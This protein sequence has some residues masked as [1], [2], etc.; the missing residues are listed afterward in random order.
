MKK[1]LLFSVFFSL[2]LLGCVNH[3]KQNMDNADNS[4]PPGNPLPKDMQISELNS[5]EVNTTVLKPVP[6]EHGRKI[7]EDIYTSTYQEHPDVVRYGRYTL[8]SSSPIGGQKYL[9]EQLVQV[10]M[11][12]KKKQYTLTVEQGI[13]N[14]LKNTGFTLCSVPSPEVRSLFN[15]QLPKVHYEFG[16]MRLRE[17]L[18]MLSGE[19]YELTVNDTLRQVCFERRNSVPKMTAPM[20]QVETSQSEGQL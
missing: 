2:G 18:Q 16:P 14:T 15:H 11:K 13:W 9:L 17:A 19:A 12:G 4:L 20:I 10:N 1:S 3:S 8:V 5:S 6:I 7:E